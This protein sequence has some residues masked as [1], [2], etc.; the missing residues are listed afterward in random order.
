VRTLNRVSAQLTPES[1]L[2]LNW[3]IEVDGKKVDDEA[4]NWLHRH[5]LLTPAEVT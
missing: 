3:R 5:G 2:F 1:L 4:G